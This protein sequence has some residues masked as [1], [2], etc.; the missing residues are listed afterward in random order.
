MPRPPKKPAKEKPREQS[1]DQSPDPPADPVDP[2]LTYVYGMVAGWARSSE[3]KQA[4]LML[5]G[6][7]KLGEVAKAMGMKYNRV[8]SMWR[9]FLG[10][11]K[12]DQKRIQQKGIADGD[13]NNIEIENDFGQEQESEH[14]EDIED[15]R[16]ITDTSD[17][18]EAE[19]VEEDERW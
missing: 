18:D 15:E 13:E 14:E 7:A 8:R 10:K 16:P 3:Q 6:G 19:E 11:V 17:D 2:R 9:H 12:D 5:I 4:L 1:A